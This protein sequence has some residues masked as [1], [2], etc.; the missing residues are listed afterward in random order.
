MAFFDEVKQKFNKTANAISDMT[1]DSIE[2]TKISSEI[3]AID[4]TV[5]KTYLAIGEAICATKG[6]MTDELRDQIAKVEELLANKEEL[7]ARK[8]QLK[9]MN[10]CP[11]C[12]AVMKD[13]ARFCSE[14]GAR[15]PE[16]VV[17]ETEKAV[18]M[19]ETEYCPDCGAMRKTTDRFCEICGHDYS[20]DEEPEQE[21]AAEE[22]VEVT[23]ETAAEEEPENFDA[24]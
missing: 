20:K 11:E 8:L 1:R 16:I 21:T 10:R 24:E 22:A 7:N 9:N 14:C 6:E 18:A 5:K 17:P 15:M 3:R 13:G 4:D 19:T 23:V 2:T 12:G